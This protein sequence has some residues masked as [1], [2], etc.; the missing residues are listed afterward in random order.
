MNDFD[1][2]ADRLPPGR[3]AQDDDRDAGSASRWT[4]LARHLPVLLLSGLFLY[5]VSARAARLPL[6]FDEIVTYY[7]SVLDSPGAVVSALLAKMDNH[8]PLDYLLRHASMALLG[9]SELAFRLPSMAGILGGAWCLY[10]FAIRRTSTAAALVAFSFPFVTTALGAAYEGRGYALLMA[11]MCLSLV[12]WQ[13]AA[14]KPTL[15]RLLLLTIALSAGPFSHFYGVLN[16]IPIAAGEA[17][18]S[19]ERRQISWP[20]VICFVLSLASLSLLVPFAL[21][22]SAFA[23]GFW[24]KVTLG[25]ITRGYIE[26]LESAV[27]AFVVCLLVFAA[28]TVFRRRS[29]GPVPAVP[30]YEIMAAAML[31]V[32]PV[33]TYLLAKFVTHA[34][35][36]KYLLNTTCGL[37]LLA[38]YAVHYISR[39]RQVAS[40]LMALTFALWAGA[41]IAR[42]Q[43]WPFEGPRNIERVTNLISS[44]GLPVVVASNHQFLKTYFYLSEAARKQLFIIVDDRLALHFGGNGSDYRTFRNLKPFVPINAADLCSFTKDHGEFLILFYDSAWIIDHLIRDEATV[45]ILDPNFFEAQLL[46][47]TTKKASG[48]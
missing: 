16:Y 11:F 46:R 26:M 19:W 33:T 5:F 10:L 36:T 4:T 32:L 18:R 1:P 23:T 28:M 29:E 30:S 8:P 48:C 15:F 44:T 31:C 25:A 41:S 7:V 9:Q 22:A 3:D 42:L 17:W 27:P 35:T 45:V 24:T 21:N 39:W 14:E 20:I 38:A 2:S 47:V 40:A 37:A 6:W 34:Y 43:P 12:A 13:R